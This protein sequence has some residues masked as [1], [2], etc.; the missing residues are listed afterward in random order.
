MSLAELE[1]LQETATGLNSVPF[2]Y[3][4]TLISCLRSILILFS[5]LSVSLLSPVP[6]FFQ[7]K[8]SYELPSP[9]AGYEKFL[10]HFSRKLWL[11][12]SAT[13]RIIAESFSTEIT[14]PQSVI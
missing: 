11:M 4:Y 1:R 13:N 8:L 14:V 12:Q 3:S 6:S 5:Q 2:E 9:K 10:G 7:T